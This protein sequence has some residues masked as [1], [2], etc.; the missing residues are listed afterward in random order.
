MKR[1][2]YFK[3]GVCIVHHLFGGDVC[4]VVQEIYGDAYLTAHFEV[5]GEMF[6]LAMDAKKRGMGIVGSTSNILDFIRTTVEDQISKRTNDRLQFVLGTESGMITSIVHAVQNLLRNHDE[7]KDLS[8][9]IV[10]PVS[11][12]SITTEKQTNHSSIHFP[13]ELFYQSRLG[14]IRFSNLRSAYNGP[15]TCFWRRLFR[16]RRMRQLSLYEN[17]HT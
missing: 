13:G 8:V 5:P 17:E 16:R 3:E 11:P 1:F 6:R 4:R 9:E 2:D 14:S 15:R 10:F 7:L 12:K